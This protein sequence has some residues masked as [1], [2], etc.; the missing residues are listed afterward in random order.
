MQES[1]QQQVA[2]VSC[3]LEQEQLPPS[4]VL[5]ASR[6]QV[7]HSPLIHSVGVTRWPLNISP[8][9]P[10]FQPAERLGRRFGTHL[11]PV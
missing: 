5:Q 3:L 10:S 2:Q 7:N 11:L 1:L 8:S 9:D 6:L 4:L